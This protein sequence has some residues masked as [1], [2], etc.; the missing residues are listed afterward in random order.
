MFEGAPINTS[1]GQPALHVALRAPSTQK[2]VVNGID[3]VKEVQ[4][5]RHSMAESPYHASLFQISK[6]P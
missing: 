1:E 3:V 2:I 6:A 5:V 4:Q